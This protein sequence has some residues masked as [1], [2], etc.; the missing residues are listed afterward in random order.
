MLVVV[1]V[2]AFAATIGL[3]SITHSTPH[4]TD[5]SLVLLLRVSG[6]GTVVFVVVV[7]AAETWLLTAADKAVAVSTSLKVAGS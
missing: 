6:G 3:R 7:T 5:I 1:L 4:S 2:G